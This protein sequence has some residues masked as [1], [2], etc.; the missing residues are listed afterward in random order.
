MPVGVARRAL[1]RVLRSIQ[2][3]LRGC[4]NERGLQGEGVSTSVF[5]QSADIKQFEHLKKAEF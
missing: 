1:Q 5:G 3:S 4:S 2:V